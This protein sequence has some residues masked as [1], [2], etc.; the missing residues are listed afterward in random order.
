MKTGFAAE[1]TVSP[2]HRIQA[3]LTDRSDADTR[4]GSGIRPGSRWVLSQQN[5]GGGR[6][7]VRGGL[8]EV[9]GCCGGVGVEGGGGV[10]IQGDWAISLYAGGGWLVLLSWARRQLGPWVSPP[11]WI[12]PFVLPRGGQTNSRLIVHRDSKWYRLMTQLQNFSPV[13]EK[14]KERKNHHKGVSV[15]FRS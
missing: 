7:R 1:A 9:S 11:H 15:V 13:A 10:H 8:A 12:Q 14:K 5:R 6:G 2:S 3:A 4:S